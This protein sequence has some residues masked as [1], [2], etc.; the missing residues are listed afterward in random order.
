MKIKITALATLLILS[1]IAQA[2]EFWLEPAKFRY[3]VGEK[4]TINFRVGDN[5]FG[6]P[7]LTKLEKLSKVEFHSLKTV[8]DITALAKEG[9]KENLSV[10]LP[11]EGTYMVVMEGNPSFSDETAE[12]FNAYLKDQG[13]DDVYNKR[14][15][16]NALEKNGTEFYTRYSKVL[17]Q[18]GK[19]TDDTYK[20]VA[21]LPIEII[22]QQNPYT[23]KV[24]DPV[25]FIVRYNGKPL[26]GALVKVFNRNNN[27]T[28]IQT[29]YTQQDGSI[30]THISN[31]G[32]WMLNVVHIIPSTDPKAEWQSYWG[33]LTFGIE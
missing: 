26:F 25:K 17:L 15:K 31:S 1:F 11:L 3:A 7:W 24:G 2:H 6:A 27:R 13:L 21:G 32:A 9:E 28:T 23:R 14:K 19:R 20:K 18:A 30:E 16:A 33:S 22:P 8:K 5:F 10:Q 4:A 12:Q 29:V